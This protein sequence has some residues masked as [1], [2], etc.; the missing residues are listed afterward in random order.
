MP[1]VS[2]SGDRQGGFVN[3]EGIVWI[4]LVVFRGKKHINFRDLE[5][6]YRDVKASFNSEEMLQFDGENG[7]IPARLLGQSVVGDDVGPNLVRRQI[8][9]PDRGHL[10]EPKQLGSR[11]PAMAGNNCV[12][13]I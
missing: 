10:R 7:F 1:K 4:W 13:M 6:G 5:A 8:L 11:H 3:F 2:Q 12:A 9:Y